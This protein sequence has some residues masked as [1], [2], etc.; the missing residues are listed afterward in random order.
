MFTERTT[1]RRS[2]LKTLV[3]GVVVAAGGGAVAFVRS[4]GYAV[5]TRQLASLSP[6]EFA[7]VEQAARRIVQ[8]DRPDDRTIP[9]ADDTDVAGFVDGYASKMPAPMRRDLSR[10]LLYLEQIAPLGKGLT[11]RFSELSPEE[12]DHVLASL[13]S[14]GVMALRGAWNGIKSL[15]FM[16]Y[17]RDPRTWS[18]VEYD[19]PL[20]G[21]SGRGH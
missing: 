6:W 20:L 9:S 19:G 14:S 13:E 21:R 8:P 10:A 7:V 16:G 3:F 18:I 11:K 4:R 17:Y 12:Q 1:S 15:V 5:P 2:A